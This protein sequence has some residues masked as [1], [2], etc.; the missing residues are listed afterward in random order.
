MKGVQFQ[1]GRSGRIPWGTNRTGQLVEDG[2]KGSMQRKV[3]V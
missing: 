3:P 2:E 1:A